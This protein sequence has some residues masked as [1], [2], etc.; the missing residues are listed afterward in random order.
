MINSQLKLPL[1]SDGLVN[2]FPEE[3]VREGGEHGGGAEK[4]EWYCQKGE[5]GVEG[6]TECIGRFFYA[7]I[8]EKMTMIG[9]N[10]TTIASAV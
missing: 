8:N 3:E 4:V 7:E 5:R 10:L 6:G 2:P 1:L 9:W